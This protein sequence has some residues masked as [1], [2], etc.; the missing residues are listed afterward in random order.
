MFGDPYLRGLM[1]TTV[2]AAPATGKWPDFG[3]PTIV[4]AA[5]IRSTA[6]TSPLATHDLN[7]IVHRT[8]S[9]SRLIFLTERPPMLL[10][11][12]HNLNN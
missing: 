11:E 3:V 10:I 4:I 1:P 6:I 12:Q 9:H 5:A 2:A 7:D 8:R